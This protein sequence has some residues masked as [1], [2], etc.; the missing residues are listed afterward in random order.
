MNKN[1]YQ[2]NKQRNTNYAFR[3]GLRA[4]I[5]F[6]LF[7][8]SIYLYLLYK[9]QKTELDLPL[10]IHITYSIGGKLLSAGVWVLFGIVCIVLGRIES[11]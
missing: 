5:L 6:I 2:T 4:G 3:K 8:A 7:G 9:E 11:N 1:L 10:L